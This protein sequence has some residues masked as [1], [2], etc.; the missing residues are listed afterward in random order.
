MTRIA[1]ALTLFT[2]TLAPLAQ[3]RRTIAT[4]PGTFTIS[5]DPASDAG[6]G[7]TFHGKV[8]GI[9][10]ALPGR[11]LKPN[12]DGPFPAV[13][14]NHGAEG[15]AAMIARIVGRTMREW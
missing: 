1:I 13:V 15:N 4:A 10:Y 8:D 14:L 6:A 2:A 11:L 3:S 12:G 7:W 5:G 9:T